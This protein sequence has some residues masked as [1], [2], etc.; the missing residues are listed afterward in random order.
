MKKA[1]KAKVV[2]WQMPLLDRKTWKSFFLALTSPMKSVGSSALQTTSWMQLALI[3]YPQILTLWRHPAHP[4]MHKET[5]LDR[6][7]SELCRRCRGTF[8]DRSGSGAGQQCF[9]YGRIR[10]VQPCMTLREG[11]VC[12]VPDGYIAARGGM[13]AKLA[14]TGTGKGSPQIFRTMFLDADLTSSSYESCAPAQRRL[15]ETL[16]Q[17]PE[18]ATF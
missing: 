5:S 3:Q 16:V 7:S 1:S 4:T 6:V 11:I 15:K 13:L 10:P 18:V 2:S 8:L 17:V 9:V 12:H 14:E